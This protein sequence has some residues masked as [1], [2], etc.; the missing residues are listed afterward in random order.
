[1][2][3][4]LAIAL[5]SAFVAVALGDIYMHNPRGCNN[6]LNDNQQNTRNQQR[7]FDSQNNAKGKCHGSLLSMKAQTG[8][9]TRKTLKRIAEPKVGLYRFGLVGGKTGGLML[10]FVFRLVPLVFLVNSHI[11]FLSRPEGL[12]MDVL[13]ALSR[14]IV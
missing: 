2:K 3:G 12:Y 13:R 5:A 14:I 9:Y 10:L 1:M 8:F 6:K 7:L 4:L 11:N